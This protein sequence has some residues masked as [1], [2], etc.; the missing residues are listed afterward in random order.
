MTIDNMPAIKAFV[1][2]RIKT[3]SEM[4]SGSG[5]EAHSIAGALD[6]LN[7][8]ASLLNGLQKQSVMLQAAIDSGQ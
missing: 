4:Q 6:E 1:Q 5:A 2:Q 3:L 8:I 7:M